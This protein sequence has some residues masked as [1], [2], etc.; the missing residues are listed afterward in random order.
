MFDLRQSFHLALLLPIVAYGRGMSN[1]LDNANAMTSVLIDNGAIKLSLHLYNTHGTQ[2]SS[3]FELRGDLELEINEAQAYNQE[4]GWCIAKEDDSTATNDDTKSANWDC[5]RVRTI[6]D[7][8][9]LDDSSG[10][11]IQ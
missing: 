3:I 10:A 4:F 9:L 6:I 1:G 8:V 7:P 11:S 5:M 2:N